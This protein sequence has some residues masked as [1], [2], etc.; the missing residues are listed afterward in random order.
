MR[1]QPDRRT[2]F[3]TPAPHRTGAFSGVPRGGQPRSRNQLII[4][5]FWAV[6]SLW[7][8]ITRILRLPEDLDQRLLG[9]GQ[10]AWILQTAAIIESTVFV[11][12]HRRHPANRTARIES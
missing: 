6:T 2:H 5:A 12:P 10:V 1:L 3:W 9:V 7:Q 4:L 8:P 11:R